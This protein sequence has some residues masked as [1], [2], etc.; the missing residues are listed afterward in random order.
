MRFHKAV[1]IT[2]VEARSIVAHRSP[3]LS[4]VVVIARGDRYYDVR[5][6]NPA[7]INAFVDDLARAEF[8]VLES[9]RARPN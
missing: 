8:A 5:G 2:K 6:M 9:D 7:E 1:R 4:E 3:A